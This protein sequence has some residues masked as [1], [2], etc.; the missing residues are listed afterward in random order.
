MKLHVRMTRREIARKLRRDSVVVKA[1]KDQTRLLET[2]EILITAGVFDDR[3]AQA[4]HALLAIVIDIEKTVF[5]P[6][7][8]FGPSLDESECRGHQDEFGN[9]RVARGV[10]RGQ[11]SAQTRADQ[12]N[13][14]VTGRC[15]NDPELAGDGEVLEVAGGEVGHG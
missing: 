15:L 11:V 6:A 9:F 10:E 1:M 8:I 7:V 13:R 12:A 2:G 4:P 14:F 3:V 5:P